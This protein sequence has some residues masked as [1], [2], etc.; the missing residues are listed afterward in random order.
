MANFYKSLYPNEPVNIEN[1]NTL[2]NTIVR[3]V[4]ENFKSLLEEPLS[5]DECHK[6]L[7]NMKPDKS[8]WSDGLPAEFYNFC[9]DEIGEALVEILNFCYN[10]S[11]LS[12][13]MRFAII[14]LLYK[15]GDYNEL[16]SSKIGDQSPYLILITK[17]A[18]K[19]LQID[20]N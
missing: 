8:T 12:E 3:F 14:S 6:A 10:R 15:K 11:L 4:P 17:L 20:C 7:T 19:P 2:L 16:N 1:Q 9:L 18:R 5:A 13:S